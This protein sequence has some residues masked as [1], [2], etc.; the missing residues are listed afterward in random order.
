MTSGRLATKMAACGV[1]LGL[2]MLGRA[3]F[4]RWGATSDE[5]RDDLPGDD[6]VTD[7]DL[8]ATRALTMRCTSDAA[9]P[10]IAQLG[11]GR[12]GFYSYDFLENLAGC[13]I[14]SA[15]RIV[16]AWQRVCVGDEVRLFPDGGLSVAVVEPPRALVLQGGVGAGRTP[17]PFDFSWAFVLRERNDGTTRLVV[18]ERYHFAHWWVRLLV[19]P[20]AV[21]S[22]VM[23]EK[24]L[25]GIRDRAERSDPGSPVRVCREQLPA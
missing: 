12:G 11:Q 4:L 3:R 14:Q 22:F 21:V 1:V 25:R 20:V 19:E 8:V 9:W 15:D 5:V 7:A 13:D 16:A 17:L 23:S 10:W 18:R 6:L 2:T 24:M